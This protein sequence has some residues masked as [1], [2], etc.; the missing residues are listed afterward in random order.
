MPTA[1]AIRGMISD[2]SELISPTLRMMIN[3]GTAPTSVVI[4]MVA[5][6]K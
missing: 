5:I 2:H 6:T 1:V 4:I 3:R